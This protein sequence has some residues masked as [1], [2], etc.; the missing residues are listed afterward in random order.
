MHCLCLA[1]LS[2][3]PPV[4]TFNPLSNPVLLYPVIVRWPRAPSSESAS[5]DQFS[6]KSGGSGR[7]LPTFICEVIRLYK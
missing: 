5:G 6:S 4:C 1:Q 7:G 3:C 2:S